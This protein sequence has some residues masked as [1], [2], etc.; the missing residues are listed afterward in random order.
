MIKL[1]F[2]CDYVVIHRGISS[3]HDGIDMGYSKTYGGPN[4]VIYAPADGVV[5]YVKNAYKSTTTSRIYGNYVKIKHADGITTLFGHLLYNSIVVKIGQQVKKGE[6]IAL[7]GNTGYSF[8][9][10]LHYEVIL[11]GVKQDP[12]KYTY[13]TSKHIVNKSTKSKYKLKF[14]ESEVTKVPDNK[15]DVNNNDNISNLKPPEIDDV[16]FEYD[17]LKTGMYKI[18]LN[19]NEKLVIKD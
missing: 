7:M 2:P 14:L 19:E 13:Y 18:R 17:C 3:N 12:L 5:T 8:G 16:I 10:H 15:N 11:N 4:H 6:K 9:T 1:I